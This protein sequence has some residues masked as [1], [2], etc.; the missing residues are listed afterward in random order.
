MVQEAH[1]IPVYPFWHSESIPPLQELAWIH[2]ITFGSEAVNV[3]KLS[4]Y[5]GP[6]E[7]MLLTKLS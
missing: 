3:E 2:F 7:W 5:P 1:K 6:K 4:L